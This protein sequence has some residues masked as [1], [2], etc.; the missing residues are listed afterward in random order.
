MSQME[1]GVLEIRAGYLALL[2]DTTFRSISPSDPSQVAVHVKAANLFRQMAFLLDAKENLQ[3]A[4][5]ELA[6]LEHSSGILQ[7]LS[8]D[9]LSA[10]LG[11]SGIAKPGVRSWAVCGLGWWRGSR[12]VGRRVKTLA[13]GEEMGGKN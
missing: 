5:R 6:Q 4:K 13:E 10:F 9:F 8:P 1:R 12:Y 3:G 7:A 2:V 11:E